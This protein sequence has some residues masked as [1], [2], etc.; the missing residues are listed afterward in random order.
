MVL[1]NRSCTATGWT[2]CCMFKSF[3][4]SFSAASLP[5]P[6]TRVCLVCL[7]CRLPFA[8]CLVC[9]LPLAAFMNPSIHTARAKPY[10]LRGCD[11]PKGNDAQQ[12]DGIACHQPGLRTQLVCDTIASKYYITVVAAISGH[13]VHRP[14]SSACCR[15]LPISPISMNWLLQTYSS[16]PFTD[17]ASCSGVVEP[18]MDAPHLHPTL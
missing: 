15:A 5:A 18:V 11:L 4:S 12:I 13:I 2:P 8:V 6:G 9:L 1:S 14:S 17:M 10:L 7:V 3:G 16:Y